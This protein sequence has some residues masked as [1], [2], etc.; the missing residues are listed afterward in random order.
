[1][2]GLNLHNKTKSITTNTT[3][4]LGA[5]HSFRYVTTDVPLKRTSLGSYTAASTTIKMS[6]KGFS[7]AQYTKWTATN[8]GYVFASKSN[9]SCEAVTGGVAVYRGSGYAGVTKP[10]LTYTASSGSLKIVPA[11]LGVSAKAGSATAEDSVYL[12][13]TVYVYYT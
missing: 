2:S 9:L 13:T 7:A 3:T 4:D 5:L 1:M 10:T 6:T 12:S 8:F 11:L